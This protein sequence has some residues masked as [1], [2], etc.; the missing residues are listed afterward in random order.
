MTVALP[1]RVRKSDESLSNV[2]ASKAMA[3]LVTHF[4]L[5]P[6]S[7]LHFQA[8]KGVTGLPNRSLQLELARLEQFAMV[9]RVPDGRLVRY[10]ALPAHT[11]WCAFRQMV[12]EFADPA[13][14]LRVAVAGVPS[15][16]AAFIFGSFANEADIHAR[17]D[18]DVFVVGAALGSRAERIALSAET[19]EAAGLLG[20]EINLARYT[21]DELAAR[22]RAH[23][24]FV[25][26]VLSGA[27]RWLVGDETSLQTAGTG[28]DR[29]EP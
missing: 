7:A 29:H 1:A 12:R 9:Q 20:R 24:P 5:H 13:E 16:T 25:T 27:K 23:S 14:V 28:N 17:S 22:C 10:V 18:I 19:L 11:R 3:R 4:V 8:L 15:V 21:P 2:L 6:D 26:S